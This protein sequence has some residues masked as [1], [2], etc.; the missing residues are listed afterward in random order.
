MSKE[1]QRRELQS[2]AFHQLLDNH[3]L[4]CNW[5][6][7]VGKS[8]VAIN[9]IDYLD[10][11]EEKKKI[12]LLVGET[13]HK[14]NWKNEFIIT[15]GEERAKE[16]LPNVRM[17]C[18]NSISKCTGE[19]WDLI[20]ADEGHHLRSDNRIGHLRN[21]D[22]ERVL[23]LSA[24]L[25]E[26]GDGDALLNALN[27]VF[28]DFTTLKYDIQ[29]AIDD[30]IL[31]TPNI[32]VIPLEMWDNAEKRYDSITE[33]LEKK[34]KEY[35]RAMRDDG[36]FTK[37]EDEL[38]AMKGKMLHAGSMRKQYLG[39]LKTNMAKRI[40]QEYEKQGLRYICF[41]ANIQQVQK[42]GGQNVIN[43]KQSKKTN[44]EVIDNFNE[45][46]TNSIFAVGMLQE[47]VSLKN[48]QAGLI[49]QLDGKARSFV[50]KFG[51]VMRSDDP[52]LKIIYIPESRDEDYLY[53]AL[54]NVKQEYIHGWDIQ[55]YVKKYGIFEPRLIS[56]RQLVGPPASYAEIK[57]YRKPFATEIQGQNFTVYNNGQKVNYGPKI[58]GTFGDL[59][60]DSTQGLIYMTVYSDNGRS[61]F[62]L[63]F[64]WRKSLG[65]LMPLA[66]ATKN[67]HSRIQLVLEPDGQFAKT[68]IILNGSELRWAKVEIPKEEPGAEESLRL[69]LVNN[70]I[71]RIHSIYE[72]DKN[73]KKNNATTANT[74]A[75]QFAQRT[76]ERIQ[77]IMPMAP[78]P[79][80][81]STQK[82]PT[83]RPPYAG[84]S[85]NTT[86]YTQ[87]KLNLW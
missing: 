48:I 57:K 1:E 11:I 13:A 35:T 76:E 65:V 39:Q 75:L 59:M 77:T 70:L 69:N 53:N 40:L 50:Q 6:T 43:S 83:L 64:P 58:Q 7:G 52:V 8:R 23:V 9:F 60:V 44:N 49:V 14:K 18:Y 25:S 4:I 31:P 33:Y 30:G 20:V 84:I 56:T 41:C 37:T 22:A 80:P 61:A 47:G 5:G 46:K 81:A 68:R 79:P 86:N 82:Q 74:N 51:R 16:L 2:N 67:Y 21:M 66:S 42:L 34:K 19:R 71:D 28:G 26:R 24:T 55:T 10:L 72:T 54:K 3:R 29:D 36:F 15:L 32:Y 78:A 62:A 87:G 85:G 63:R 12:L 17:E 73:S 38:E 45:E 27:E